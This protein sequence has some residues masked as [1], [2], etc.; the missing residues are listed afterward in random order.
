VYSPKEMKGNGPWPNKLL[1]G[2][3]LDKWLSGDCT[4]VSLLLRSAHMRTPA[5]S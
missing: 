3:I 1:G 5:L 2:Q 4:A